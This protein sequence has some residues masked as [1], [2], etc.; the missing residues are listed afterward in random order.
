[1]PNPALEMLDMLRRAGCKESE[2]DVESFERAAA[3]AN[4][5]ISRDQPA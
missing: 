3:S 4:E 1:M 2:I 5:E